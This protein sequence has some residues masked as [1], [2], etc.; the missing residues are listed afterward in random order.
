MLDEVQCMQRLHKFDIMAIEGEACWKYDFSPARALAFVEAKFHHMQQ[1]NLIGHTIPDLN[2][3]TY[4]WI[5][6]EL[7]GRNGKMERGERWE[8]LTLYDSNGE[9]C[10]DW[11]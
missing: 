2:R 3:E 1:V 6:E 7:H 8:P 4:E 5:A 10:A 11:Y 9:A